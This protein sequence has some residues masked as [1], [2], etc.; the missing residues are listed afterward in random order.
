MGL[1]SRVIEGAQTRVEGANFD[2]R[3]HVLEYDDVLNSQ[4][5]TIYGQRDRIF[6]KED[7]SEDVGEMLEVEV[8]ARVPEALEDEE[9]PWRLLAWLEQ[10]QPT[11]S[12]GEV[13]FPSFSLKLLVNY[14]KDGDLSSK[15]GVLGRMLELVTEALQAQEEHLLGSA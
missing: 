9:G 5:E 2:R 14:V 10:I 7:L 6:K 12:H 11:F 4:R 13:I 8:A 1:V 3:K 15:E